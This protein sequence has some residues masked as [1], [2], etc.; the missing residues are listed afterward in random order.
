[1]SVFCPIVSWLCKSGECET[2][3]LYKDFLKETGMETSIEE[4]EVIA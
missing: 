4:S 2:C 1:M 3:Y